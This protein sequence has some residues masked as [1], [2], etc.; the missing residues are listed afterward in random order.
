MNAKLRTLWQ[1][2]APRERV[3][4]VVLAV[5]VGIAS[6][7]WLVLSADQAHTRLRASVPALRAQAVRLEQQAAE[8]EHLRSAPPASVSTTDLRTLVQAQA[9][10]AGLSRAL[11]RIDALDANQVVVVFGA[12]A[13]ADWLNWVAS[14]KSQQVRLD[15]CRVEALSTPGL[16]SV[17]ATLV[18][19][20]HQ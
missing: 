2:R 13:F 7:V 8:L 14:L 18:R 6:Y 20:K 12:V 17:T 4:I 19:S 9:G 15:A 3:V 11:G 16:V 1:S 5:L 10:A